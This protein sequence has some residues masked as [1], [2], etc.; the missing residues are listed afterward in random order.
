MAENL[1][2]HPFFTNIVLPFIF[3][4]V[5][6]YALMEKIKLLENKQ[7]HL[8]IALAIAFF[9]IG[10]PSLLNITSVII[11]VLAILVIIAFSIMLLFG[12]LGIEFYATNK[13]SPI[14]A[15]LAVILLIVGIIV[16]ASSFGLF[17]KISSW[18]SPELIQLIAFLII[19]GVVVAIIVGFKTNKTK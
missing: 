13:S 15:T 1:L 4:F 6:T 12:M 2:F 8:L 18:L 14:K 7:A 3:V 17:Q 9:F 10:V 16:V 5:L 11:P 19:T